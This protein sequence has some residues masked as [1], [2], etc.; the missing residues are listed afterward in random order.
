MAGHGNVGSAY[1]MTLAEVQ[2]RLKNVSRRSPRPEKERKDAGA[3]PP[4]ALLRCGQ[5]LIE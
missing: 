1:A 2:L 4:R 3:V 5:V